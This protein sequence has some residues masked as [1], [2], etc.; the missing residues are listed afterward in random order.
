[1]QEASQSSITVTETV[2]VVPIGLIIWIAIRTLQERAETNS[3][4]EK[5]ASQ[6][7]DGLYMTPDILIMNS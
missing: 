1:M 7:R 3:N 4:Q 5:A 2:C 6:N